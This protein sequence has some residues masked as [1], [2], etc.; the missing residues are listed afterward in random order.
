M[1][2]AATGRRVT[3]RASAPQAPP[4]ARGAAAAEERD[5]ALVDAVAEQREHAGST[6]TEPMTAIATTT[7]VAERHRGEDGEAGEQ[8]PGERRP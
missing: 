5:A 1:T 4:P 7:I 6:V 8:Q 3:T 2:S